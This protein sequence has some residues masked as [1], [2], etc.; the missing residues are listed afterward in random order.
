M[1]GANGMHQRL[2]RLLLMC[3]DCAQHSEIDMLI[4]HKHSPITCT[5]TITGKGMQF[6]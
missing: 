4:D 3:H 5:R 1:P 2:I 6:D